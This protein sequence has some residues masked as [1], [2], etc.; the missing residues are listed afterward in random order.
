MTLGATGVYA[1]AADWATGPEPVYTV[2][3]RRLLEE[4]PAVLRGKM[5]LDVGSGTGVVSRLLTARGATTIE[6]DLSAAML[7]WQRSRRPPAVVGD[8]GRMPIRDDSVDVVLAGFVLNHLAPVDPGLRE[9]ARVL[10]RGGR[11]FA[12]TWPASPDPVKVI[13]EQVLREHGW[14]P[15]AWHTG[16]RA[17]AGRTGDPHLMTSACEAAG[18]QGMAK[19]VEVDL[20]LSAQQ[21]AGWRVG[22]PHTVGWLDSLDGTARSRI[23]VHLRETFAAYGCSTRVSMLMI[24]VRRAA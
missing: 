6:L 11:L 19:I 9:V 3:G 13:G 17:E 5:C 1:A 7:A 22:L 21:L 16:M 2:L 10:R 14:S 24:D 18:L 23:L 15:P 12:S 20:A 4:L 8:V